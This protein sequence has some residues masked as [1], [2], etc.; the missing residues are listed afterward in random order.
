M[1][2]RNQ[3]L[4]RGTYVGGDCDVSQCITITTSEMVVLGSVAVEH[5]RTV[6]CMWCILHF[7]NRD[8][9]LRYAVYRRVTQVWIATAKRFAELS[10]GGMTKA[11]ECPPKRLSVLTFAPG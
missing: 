10:I 3:L 6:C 2:I 5:H 9:A 11:G 8:E 7:A 1:A 4:K